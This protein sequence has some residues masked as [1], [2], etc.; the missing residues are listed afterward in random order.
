MSLVIGQPLPPLPVFTA[1]GRA[2][3]A[4][5]HLHPRGTLLSFLHGT[6]CPDCVLQLRR[7]RRLNRD[8]AL[9]MPGVGVLA[10]TADTLDALLGFVM[11]AQPP[12]GYPML[13]DPSGEAHRQVQA[14]ATLLVIVDGAG[15]VRW[16]ARAAEHRDLPGFAVV[17]ETLGLTLPTLA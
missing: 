4:S 11:S 6:W 9:N 7:L 15:E 13:A 14:A 2:T 8:L 16:L 3:S 1:E 5:A 17:L 12:L 10:L